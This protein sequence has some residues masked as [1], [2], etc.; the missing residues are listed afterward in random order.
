TARMSTWLIEQDAVD[1]TTL[2]FF[3]TRRSSDLDSLFERN[4]STDKY[5]KHKISDIKEIEFRNASFSYPKSEKDALTNINLKIKTGETVAIV[6]ENG[7]G[8]TTL[9]NCL[10]GLYVLREGQILVNGINIKNIDPISLR[11]HFT[12]IFQDFM[13]Y[14][15]SIYENI[16]LGDVTKKEKKDSVIEAA[17]KSGVSYFSN[18]LREGLNTQLGRVFENGVDLSGGQW[19]KIAIARSIFRTSDVTIL[20]EPTASLDPKSEVEIYQQFKQLALDKITIFISHRLGHTKDVD[21]IIVLK[22][23]RIVEQGSH[24]ELL[25][26]KK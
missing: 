22:H 3:P 19:Q 13:K 16:V 26:K 20:D 23:G 1:I 8:K 2:H 21:K 17:Q 14:S 25:N 11:K 6:G 15:F 24:L 7:S 5:I 10:L 18:S 4:N 9:I 12:V